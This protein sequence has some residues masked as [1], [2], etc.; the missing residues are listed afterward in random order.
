MRH[1]WHQTYSPA[2]SPT[3]LYPCIGHRSG[4]HT[5]LPSVQFFRNVSRCRE[6]LWPFMPRLCPSG[7][8]CPGT[9]LSGRTT[10]EVQPGRVGISPEGGSW[11]EPEGR[12]IGER[13][14]KPRLPRGFGLSGLRDGTKLPGLYLKAFRTPSLREPSRFSGQGLSG[15]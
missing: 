12:A 10:G 2:L 5:P 9:G 7:Q 8:D 6:W 11:T 13:R 15:T 1:P 4:G 14:G 3:R